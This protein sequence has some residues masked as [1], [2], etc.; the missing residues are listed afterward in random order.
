MKKRKTPNRV[1]SSEIILPLGA[2]PDKATTAGQRALRKKHGT[3]RAFASAVVNAIGEIS[4]L[5]AQ[6]AIRKYRDEWQAA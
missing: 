1:C 5:E 4:I 2:L 3:P 6:L